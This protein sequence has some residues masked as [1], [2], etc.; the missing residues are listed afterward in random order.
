LVS[1]ERF[2]IPLSMQAILAGRITV[3]ESLRAL[4]R[5][6]SVSHETIRRSLA[7]MTDTDHHDAIA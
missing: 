5:E 1:V 2:G 4:A 6:Y 3:G 7:R